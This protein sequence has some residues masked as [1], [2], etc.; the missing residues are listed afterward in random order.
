MARVAAVLLGVALVVAGGYGFLI[1]VFTAGSFG[2]A[3]E[4]LCAGAET[5]PQCTALRAQEA[6]WNGVMVLSFLAIVAGVLLFL[7]PGKGR[8][9][10]LVEGP[11]S[12]V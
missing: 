2:H 5:S 7:V 8:D 11:R 12:P 9:E 4:G 3:E 6:F 1:Y 10:G